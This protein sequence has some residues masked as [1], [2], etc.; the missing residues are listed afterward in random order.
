MP[1]T[2][3]CL[4]LI[5]ARS[6]PFEEDF[7]RR[8]RPRKG[9][10]VQRGCTTV[11]VPATIYGASQ[12]Q[13]KCRGCNVIEL[14]GKMKGIIASIVFSCGNVF[15]LGKRVNVTIFGSRK[16]RERIRKELARASSSWWLLF[17]KWRHSEFVRFCF[18]FDIF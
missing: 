11:A 5:V 4:K 2:V 6:I 1:T 3:G 10:T 14:C 15:Y 17:R 7:H 18:E 16:R 12:L 9:S 13:Q 8:G